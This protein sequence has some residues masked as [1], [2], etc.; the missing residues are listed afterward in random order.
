[1]LATSYRYIGYNMR[2]PPF[3]DR[4]VRWAMAHL[5]DLDRIKKTIL[6]DL[7]ERTTGPFLPQSLQYNKKLPPIAYDPQRAQKLLAEAGYQ[8][9]AAGLLAKD[10]KVLE[11]EL[12]FPAGGGFAD[13]MVSVL[14]ED[15]TRAGIVLQPRKLEFQA[16]ITKVNERDF[17]AVMLGWASG[18][19][20][21]PFQLWHTSQRDKGHNFTGFGNAESDALI[22]RARLTFDDNARNAIYHRF[23]ELLYNEQPYTFLFT[24]YALIA[25]SRRFSSVEVYP[26]GLEILEWRLAQPVF[27]H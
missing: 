13:Q 19:E 2:R 10:G 7:A 26:L 11:F 15:F 27:Q 16:L 24:S 18:I 1:Y 22:E 14:K 3:N 21:D 12:L 4:R 23:H 9:N 8:R 17:Q 25:V 6:E 20:S 5:M